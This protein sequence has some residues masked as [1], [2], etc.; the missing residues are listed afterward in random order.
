MINV[1]VGFY[2]RILKQ[3]TDEVSD[4]WLKEKDRRVVRSGATTKGL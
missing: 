3:A 1:L 4:S 2:Y